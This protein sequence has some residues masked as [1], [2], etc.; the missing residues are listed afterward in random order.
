MAI[1][2]LDK[3]EWRPYFDRV[4]RH[5]P[6]TEVEI[7]VAG[8]AIGDQ[9]ETDWTALHGITY[10]PD[11]D[12]LQVASASVDHL[13]QHPREIH[14]DDS[15]QGL[16]ALRVIDGDDYE[17]IVQLRAPLQLPGAEAGS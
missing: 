17:Q 14:V 4:S 12:V 16:K 2:K 9:I 13:I 7:E 15:P 1:R 11:S 5:L 3:T 10:D 6:A 8:L